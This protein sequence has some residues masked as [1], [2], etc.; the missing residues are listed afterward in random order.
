LGQ[1]EFVIVSGFYNGYAQ[2]TPQTY[3][4]DMHNGSTDTSWRRMD[5]YPVSVGITHA[6]FTAVDK[7]LYICGG[8]VG[9]QPGP[10]TSDC[11][12]YNHSQQPGLGKQWSQWPSLPE[13]R[14]GG[15][16]IYDKQRRALLFASG[17]RRPTTGNVAAVD[18][19]TTWT[20]L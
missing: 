6:A 7:L 4:L 17:A 13:G 18:Y 19:K 8:F 5:D 9:G 3:T 14:A 1:Y 11:F 12:V 2:A 15:G 16:L 20:S 10:E